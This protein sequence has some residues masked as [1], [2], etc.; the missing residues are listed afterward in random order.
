MILI[1][2]LIGCEPVPEHE[3][4]AVGN[5]PGAMRTVLAPGDELTL[6]DAEVYVHGLLLEGCDLGAEVVRVEDWVDLQGITEI[7]VPQGSWCAVTLGLGEPVS[8]SGTGENG[9][10]FAFEAN[11]GRVTVLGRIDVEEDS[12]PRDLVLE[13]AQPGWI[14][15]DIL[16]LQPATHLD[17]GDN[18]LDDALC[19]RMWHALADGSAVYDDDDGEGDVDPEERDRGAVLEGTGRAR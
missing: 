3:G 19:L 2:L 17:L 14:S 4:I 11:V 16:G 6:D 15:Q 5:P 18:C 12:R 13:L 8:L 9:G 7:G 10:T 1:A